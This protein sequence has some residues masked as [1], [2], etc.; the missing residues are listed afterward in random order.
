MNSGIS[1]SASL[2]L[3]MYFGYTKVLFSLTSIAVSG[4]RKRKRR[5]IQGKYSSSS[6]DLSSPHSNSPQACSWTELR[7]EDEEPVGI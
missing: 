4:L 5:R 6:A 2:S 7:M 1:L 3:Y